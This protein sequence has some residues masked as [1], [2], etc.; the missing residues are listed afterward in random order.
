MILKLSLNSESI[1]CMRRASV[2]QY[3]FTAREKRL[4]SLVDNSLF[5]KI[6]CSYVPLNHYKW[7]QKNKLA[8][9]FHNLLIL[10]EWFIKNVFLGV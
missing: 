8:V 5:L 3:I 9:H 4:S 1:I 10:K 7:F 6:V 2:D